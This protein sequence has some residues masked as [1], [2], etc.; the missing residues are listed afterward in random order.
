MSPGATGKSD[1]VLEESALDR[2]GRRPFCDGTVRDARLFWK[3]KSKASSNKPKVMAETIA[4]IK[5][6]TMNNRL[7]GAERIRGEL[8][9]LDMHV[10][11]RTIQKYMRGVRPPRPTGQSWRTFLRNHDGEIWACDAPPSD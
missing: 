6:M 8:L 5:D 4:L 3:H 10:C 11:K 9:K 1:T 7:W 2:P